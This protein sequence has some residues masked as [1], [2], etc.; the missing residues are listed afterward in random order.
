MY[1]LSK[2]FMGEWINL[3]IFKGLKKGF[4]YYFFHCDLVLS[5]K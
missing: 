3:L 2:G 4:L 1:H 5:V